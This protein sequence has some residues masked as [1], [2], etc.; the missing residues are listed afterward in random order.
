MLKNS[1]HNLIYFII[2]TL[3]SGWIGVLIDL[4]LTEQ[5]EGNSLGMGIWL[6]LPFLCGIV[7]RIRE[8]EWKGF[9][10]SLNIK[11][12]WK[13]CVI[14]VFIYPAIT[15]ITLM[16]ALCFEAVDIFTASRSGFLSA[17]AASLGG[18]FLKNIFEEFAWRGYLTPG[19][20]KYNLNDW[21]IY[22]ISG[23][24]WG[25]WHTAYYMV[26]LGDEYFLTSSRPETLISGCLIMIIWS[27]LFVE[28]YRMTESVWPCVIL[29]SM[30]EAT[31]AIL[32]ATG[33]FV[34]YSGLGQTLFDPV[35]GILSIIII[36]GAGLFLRKKRMRCSH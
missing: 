30:E 11:A 21:L 12:G 1:K 27:I 14:A 29:H 26:F 22:G 9:G 20:I 10:L 18:S 4:I 36:A 34:K 33:A 23:L 8:K 32:V 13:S 5:P 6:V 15:L 3:I 7:F 16:L 17:I 31:S 28:I 19:L 2:I 24:I 25:L 35:T